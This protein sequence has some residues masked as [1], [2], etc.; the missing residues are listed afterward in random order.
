MNR[1]H[2]I[3]S[4]LTAASG[5]LVYTCQPATIKGLAIKPTN[6]LNNLQ[7]ASGDTPIPHATWYA[8]N[9]VGDGLFYS[10]D[11]GLFAEYAFLTA[12]ILLDGVNMCAFLLTLQ[13]GEDGPAFTLNF[14]LLNQCSARIRANLQWVN[15][16]VWK[17]NREG[18]W[19]KPVVGGDR[20][21][22]SQ[23]DRMTLTI[24]R[25]GEQPVRFCL[26]SFTAT[27][28]ESELLKKPILPRGKLIDELGQST[29]H[30]WSAKSV[31]R[32]H[33]TSR[34]KAQD[35]ESYPWPD[36]FSKW[37]G[38]MR[39]KFDASGFFR[40]EHDGTRWW[41]VDPDGYAFWS[42][43]CDCV[44]VDTS[45]NYK[46]LKSALTWVPEN[47]PEFAAMFSGRGDASHINYLAGNFIKAFGAGEWHEIWSSIALSQLKK[48]GFNTVGNW[49]EWDIARAAGFP[50]VRPLSLRFEKTKRIYRDFPDV[51][52]ASYKEEA[53]KYA[54]QLQET[55]EDPAFIGYF[56]MNE[57]TWGFSSEL[58]AAGMLYNTPD[59]ETRK[60]LGRF[61]ARKYANDAAFASAW[62]MD[63]TLAHITSGTWTQRFTVP[64]LQD[65][66]A[67]SEL[68]CEEF[69][70]VLTDAC[71]AVDPYHMNLGARYHKVPP[72]WALKGMRFFDV[73][74]MNCYRERIPHEDVLDIARLLGLPTMI[75]EFH[76]GALDVGLPATGIGHVKNQAARGQ[77]YRIY[78]EDAAADPNCVGTH[79]F[80]LY[81]Q[82]ALGR[83]DGENYNI[84]F[85]DVCNR[86]YEE[87]LVAARATHDIIYDVAARTTAPYADAPEYFQ[88]LF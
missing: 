79:W 39:K 72:S 77:A 84:G 13:E 21:D 31:D 53:A 37:G 26:T 7:Q 11:K 67:F 87:L 33:V 44:R 49:S 50:Y 6:L 23:V 40:K 20:I 12:D 17:A 78:V 83:F 64:A 62:G 76:F 69:F 57:P 30:T 24:F 82:S 8:G 18:A 45:A 58:P 32:A 74:S 38:W 51:F 66:A 42:A 86:P 85:L 54:E 73:F 5:L 63:V 4:S 34:L 80:T 36:Q 22:L 48:I 47:E 14:K 46:G 65:L 43:G 59:C 29:L 61:L 68:M 9:T 88:K 70:K 81:D 1:R 52:A 10:I 16:N 41:L 19:L 35:E 56:L 60:E 75:G 28:N 2:F 71:R 55:K 3:Q 27:K 15:Q 25:N